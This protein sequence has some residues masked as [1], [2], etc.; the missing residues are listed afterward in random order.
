MNHS[1]QPNGTG[2]GSADVPTFVITPYAVPPRMSSAAAP[3]LRLRRLPSATR[4]SRHDFGGTNDEE[5][6]GRRRSFSDPQRGRGLAPSQYD[7]R[8]QRTAQ[9]QMSPLE[10]ESVPIPGPSDS[11]PA[12]VNPRSFVGRLRAN[13]AWRN[14][15]GP[16]SGDSRL[17]NEEEYENEIVDWL[18]VVGKPR[19]S[20]N[21]DV[22]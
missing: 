19:C 10:E 14:S 1:S 17:P 6:T 16:L 7:L 22:H 12:A 4:V 20:S 21:F 8:R 3:P 2:E 15:I 9:S 11:R 13:P 5:R 18:D